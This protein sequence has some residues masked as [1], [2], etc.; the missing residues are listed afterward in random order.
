MIN[1]AFCKLINIHQ[2]SFWL[3]VFYVLFIFVGS[4]CIGD[5]EY[6]KEHSI[7]VE[8]VEKESWQQ[9]IISFDKAISLN[10]EYAP[11]YVD[12]G[13]ANYK[14]NNIEQ[15]FNDYS[16]AI[17]IEPTNFKALSSRAEIHAFKGD[18]QLAL[19]DLDLAI[20]EKN[21]DPSFYIM[22]GKIL[23][24]L[25][26]SD[27]AI[28]QFELALD[29]DSAS[30]DAYYNIGITYLGLYEYSNSIKYFEKAIKFGI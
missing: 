17:K 30:V 11:A 20:S 14:L 9:A 19:R 2:V 21:D 7:G 4:S 6:K 25:G 24:S 12:R 29:L 8:H 26:Q 10:K 22:K 13:F 18:F 5:P 15:A 27:D 3:I 16:E 1:N 23:G 28:K